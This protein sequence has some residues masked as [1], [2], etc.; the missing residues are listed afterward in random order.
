MCSVAFSD[1]VVYAGG[2]FATMAGQAR[3]RLAA[4]NA[5]NG[6]LRADWT[7]TVVDPFQVNTMLMSGSHLY[8]GGG[9]IQVSG[10]NQRDFADFIDNSSNTAPVVDTVSINQ[11]SP[12][13]NDNLSVTVTSH[14]RTATRSPTPTSGPR[15]APTSRAPPRPRWTCPRPRT[16]ATATAAT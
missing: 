6:A 8:V 14:D 4:L 3:S 9:F 12:G 15:T 11:S 2:H 5:N 1:G 13:T 10:Q 16:A 7:P